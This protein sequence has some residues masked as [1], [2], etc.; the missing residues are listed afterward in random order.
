MSGPWLPWGNEQNAGL[1]G[2]CQCL[3]PSLNRVSCSFLDWRSRRAK[4]APSLA[5]GSVVVI[6]QENELH[7]VELKGE[8]VPLHITGLPEANDKR[9]SLD[10]ASSPG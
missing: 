10:Q 3:P 1:Q 9:G 2:A 6:E 8:F 7:G 4:C 5:I